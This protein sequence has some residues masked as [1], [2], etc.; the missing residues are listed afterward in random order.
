MSLDV[1]MSLQIEG[2]PGETNRLGRAEYLEHFYESLLQHHSHD[3]PR[4][5]L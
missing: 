1:E 3:P 2:S 4:T 5:K